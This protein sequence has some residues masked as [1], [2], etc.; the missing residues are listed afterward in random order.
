MKLAKLDSLVVYKA[1]HWLRIDEN[2][3]TFY[4]L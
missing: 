2:I 1:T 4:V 3:C